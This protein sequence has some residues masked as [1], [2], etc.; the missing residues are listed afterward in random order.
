VSRRLVS[1]WLRSWWLGSRP[2]SRRR[3]GSALR[4]Q[5]ECSDRWCKK[6]LTRSHGNQLS[7]D[8]ER[9]NAIGL[10]E[11]VSIARV[12]LADNGIDP[13][14][15]NILRRRTIWLRRPRKSSGRKVWVIQPPPL[16]E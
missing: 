16:N 1:R 3:G 14:S 8:R 11:C 9:D 10:M 13:V 2:L 6:I 7:G 4:E 12:V 15:W 5:A